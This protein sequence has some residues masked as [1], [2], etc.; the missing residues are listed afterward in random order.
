M[1]AMA[2]KATEANAK[3]AMM[4]TEARIDGDEAAG[5]AKSTAMMATEAGKAASPAKSAAMMT[6]A[7]AQAPTKPPPPEAADLTRRMQEETAVR[8][9]VAPAAAGNAAGP[10][11]S[12]AM[13]TTAFAPTKPPPPEAA[14]F[15]RRLQE[16]T[17]VRSKVAPAAAGNAAGPAR[18]DVPFKVPPPGLVTDSADFMRRLNT[19]TDVPFK[20]PPPTLV[21]AAAM[22]QMVQEGAVE[23][24]LF[25]SPPAFTAVAPA[26]PPPPEAH[27]FM[28]ML[29]DQTFVHAN[30]PPATMAA[31]PVMAVF[32]AKK[33]PPPLP[34]AALQNAFDEGWVSGYQ[35][36][37]NQADM[38]A[39]SKAVAP[40]GPAS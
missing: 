39:K 37:K 32:A 31:S 36:A 22:L 35:F 9:K 1:Q 17:A 2:A 5:P 34:Q 12:A 18:T 15:M 25:K 30:A 38:K 19:R 13:M 21:A 11:Q 26:P 24:V 6:T 8:S 4:A 29:Q 14:D 10:A 33:A 23:V 27:D 7:F 28:R 40:K 3:A 16:G 20:T